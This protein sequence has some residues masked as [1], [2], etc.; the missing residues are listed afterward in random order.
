[1][2]KIVNI[3]I[4]I[5]ACFLFGCD[6]QKIISNI[7]VTNLKEEYLIDELKLNEI[8]LLVSYDNNETENIILDKSMISNEDLLKLDQIGNHSIKIK[9][10]DFEKEIIINI[11]DIYNVVFKVNGEVVKG[12]EV[13][14]GES[15]I[16]PVVD[17]IGDL[18]FIAW[19]KD[20]E[21]V[22]SDLEI[23]A[24]YGKEYNNVSF[25]DFYGEVIKTEI[26]KYGEKA[27]APEL[28]SIGYYLFD[29]WDKEFDYV[30]EDIEVKPIYTK[31]VLDVDQELRDKFIDDVGES[32]LS[33]FDLDSLEFLAEFDGI[34]VCYMNAN[35]GYL[36]NGYRYGNIEFPNGETYYIEIYGKLRSC[37]YLWLPEDKIPQDQTSPILS[38]DTAVKYY[39]LITKEQ[40]LSIPLPILE[41]MPED[42]NNIGT[43]DEET[44]SQFKI[45]FGNTELTDKEIEYRGTYND[46]II[47]GVR[48][49]GVWDTYQYDII[50][51]IKIAYREGNF[52]LYAYVDGTVY[53][54]QEAYEKE[55]LNYETIKKIPYYY[56][57]ED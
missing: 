25:Y 32:Y 20:Y 31:N 21:N 33:R 12:E 22:T 15:A 24:I 39:D 4:I 13:K 49:Y 5:L 54:L 47:M 37:V 1:M 36:Y 14:H 28:R 17:S 40:F 38:I 27:S 3:L 57:Y 10:Q 35:N 30:T 42:P 51:D 41:T 50:E 34:Y 23:N 8:N 45:D 52:K 9:Y 56:C 46:V 29:G 11:T 6:N 26:V 19:D 48:W 43:I 2:K 7:E 44:I 16:A 53:T 55:L 18:S